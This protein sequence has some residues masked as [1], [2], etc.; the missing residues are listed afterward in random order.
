LALGPAVKRLD[1][2]REKLLALQALAPRSWEAAA[3][4]WG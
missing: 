1:A 2:A 4:Y 3:C